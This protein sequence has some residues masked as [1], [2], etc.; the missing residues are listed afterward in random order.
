VDNPKKDI[1]SP[2]HM[3]CNI[4]GGGYEYSYEHACFICKSCGSA[5]FPPDVD[6]EDFQNMWQLWRDEQR[7]KKSMSRLTGGRSSSKKRKKPVKFIPAWKKDF[8][9]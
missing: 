5:L 6:D 4:C 9:E 2:L 3:E 8:T 1:K 7:V